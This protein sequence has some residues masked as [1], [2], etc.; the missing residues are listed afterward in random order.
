[1]VIHVDQKNTM[2]SK[3]RLERNDEVI[4]DIT[5]MRFE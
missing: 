5:D 3:Y 2:F 4:Y 1:M